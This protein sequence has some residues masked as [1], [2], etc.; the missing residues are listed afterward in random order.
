MCVSRFPDISYQS[1]YICPSGRTRFCVTFFFS[2][3][4][5][6]KKS[7]AVQSR[8]WL[9]QMHL[10]HLHHLYRRRPA[11]SQT[12][13]LTRWAT[14][15]RTLL[16]GSK[17]P[18][19]AVCKPRW[20]GKEMQLYP[21]ADLMWGVQTAEVGV[22]HISSPALCLSVS[23]GQSLIQKTKNKH[24]TWKQ[25]DDSSATQASTFHHLYRSWFLFCFQWAN[26]SDIKTVVLQV[27]WRSSKVCLWTHF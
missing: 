6:R 3:F 21:R 25:W 14:G 9:G 16:S 26:I 2:R 8:R 19:E 23:Y 7:L 10:L 12:S 24:P 20:W 11:S 22:C 13:T 15:E 18:E 4:L 27:I 17:W 5:K 1:I